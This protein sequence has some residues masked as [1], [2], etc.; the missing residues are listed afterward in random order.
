MKTNG[1][2]RKNHSCSVS[3]F[4]YWKR[5]RSEIVGNGNRSGI[6]R[7]A[8]TNGNRILTKTHNL[9]QIG[10]ILIFD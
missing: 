6:N 8:K 9:I 1:K 4:Y 5:D 10:M 7:I 3:V 2:G